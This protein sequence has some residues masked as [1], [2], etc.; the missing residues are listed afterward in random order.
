MAAS[1][2][3]DGQIVLWDMTADKIRKPLTVL[4]IM[5]TPVHILKKPS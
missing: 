3:V 5:K 1:A 2:S 4:G